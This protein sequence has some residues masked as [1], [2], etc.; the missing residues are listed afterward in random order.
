MKKDKIVMGHGSG[1]KLMRSLIKETFLR[2]LENPYLSSLSDSA[3]LPVGQQRIA[4]T[5]D[6]YVVS[7]PFFPGGDIGKLAVAGTINDLCVVGATPIFITLALI[8]EEGFPLADLEKIIGSVKKTARDSGVEV[9]TGDTKVVEKGQGDGIFINTSGV[10]L[11]PA[12]VSLSMEKIKA[13]DHIIVNG[14][15]GDHGAAVMMVRGGFEFESD[16][17]SDCASLYSLVKEMIKEKDGIHFMR[18][19]TRGGLSAALNEISEEAGWGILIRESEIPVRDAVSSICEILGLDP[20]YVANEGKVLAVVDQKKS[21]KILE[22]MRCHPL[23]REAK[24]IGEITDGPSKRVILKTKYGTSRIIDMP[25]EE[26]LP[27]I[28]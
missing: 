22:R 15:I 25:E 7:P 23:G 21:E 16:L 1:G 27:R 12:R 10:G 26:K 3:I 18:D 14:P 24:I 13:G 6:S 17:I 19:P 5:T 28:C 8:L 11:I 4:L 2:N 9:V 20:L